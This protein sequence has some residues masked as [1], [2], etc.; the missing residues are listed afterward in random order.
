[1]LK[2][3]K[4][5]VLVGPMGTGKTTIGKIL[6]KELGFSFVDS[7]RVIEER[8]GADIPWIF[9]V[10]GEPGFRDREK[11][12]IKDLTG[13]PDIVLATGGGAVVDTD[14]QSEMQKNGFI[15]FLFTTIE[16]Q[17]ERTHKDRKRPL[18]QS[19]DP[20]AVLRRLMS[21]REPIYRSIADCIVETD[22]K[23]PRVVV[24]E[25]LKAIESFND[26]YS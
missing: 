16:Q 9:D 4:N 18:L 3:K 1:M 17:Y 2:Y 8:C 14:N 19:E 13:E 11:S 7:D 21:V 6:S 5:I 20:L 26:Q 12:V 24:K 10:E 22:S 25:I 15:V 23:K